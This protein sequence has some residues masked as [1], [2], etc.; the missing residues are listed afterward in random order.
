MHPRIDQSLLKPGYE[1]T[2]ESLSGIVAGLRPSP[3]DSIL[4]VCGSGD[5]A[6]ALAEYARRVVVVD[7]SPIQLNFARARRDALAAGDTSYFLNPT[8]LERLTVDLRNEY[9]SQPG[10]LDRIRENIE[11]L[12][13]V[14]AVDVLAYTEEQPVGAF[15]KIYLSN[16]EVKVPER[17]AHGEYVGLI[18]SY[19]Y[20]LDR[21]HALLDPGACIYASDLGRCN[22][23]VAFA[24]YMGPLES[25]IGDKY[26]TH[27]K[28]WHWCDASTQAAISN[29]SD[30]VFSWSPVVLVRQ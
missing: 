30:Q 27:E 23:S 1:A 6:F 24:L 9:F 11:R 19:A 17:D 26:E 14:D 18:G 28:P 3:E 16:V 20:M 7:Y 29:R 12:E 5:Q 10:R 4:A 13:F 25:R 15:N 21:F 22:L 8:S 2:N